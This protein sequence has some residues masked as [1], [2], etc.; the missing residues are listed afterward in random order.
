M[1]KSELLEKLESLRLARETSQKVVAVCEAQV[2]DLRAEYDRVRNELKEA[3]KKLQDAVKS[4]GK[5]MLDLLKME[6]KARLSG[7][8]D[9]LQSKAEKAD[10]E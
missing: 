1:K 9:Q 2:N 5:V 4:D 3:S 8:L 10:A 7:L 6:A